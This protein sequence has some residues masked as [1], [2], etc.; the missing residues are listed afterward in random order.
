MWRR[1]TDGGIPPFWHAA[2]YRKLKKKVRKLDSDLLL[3]YADAIGTG[4]AVAF[5]DYRKDEREESLLE[6]GEALMTLSA[7][8]AELRD[9]RVA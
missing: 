6:L 7:V 3:G 8:V 1:E 5:S 9:R 4:M 2:R